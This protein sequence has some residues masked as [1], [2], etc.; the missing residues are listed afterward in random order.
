MKK[1]VITGIVALCVFAPVC[2]FS[3]TW[4]FGVAF[5]IISLVGVFEMAKCLGLKKNFAL[6]I[7]MYLASLGLPIL[8]YLIYMQGISKPN[9]VFL[10]YAMITAFILL[11]Y[12][13]AYIMFGKNKKNISDVLT[14]YALS[15]YTIGCFSSVVM[16]RFTGTELHKDIGAYMY[17][18]IFISAWVCD[19]FAYFVGRLLGKH[20]LIPEISPKK[21]VEGAIGGIVFTFIALV[22]YWCIVNFAFGYE[23]LSIIHICILGV[24]LPIVSQIGDL[25]ASSIKRQY[26]IKDFGNVFPG[27]G[28]VLD[29]FD[30][31][32]LVAPVLC[33]TNAI[34]FLF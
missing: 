16:V 9:S 10:R 32:M 23:G 1:R 2:I 15:V 14:F 33:F 30:S 4:F 12:S 22:G 3:G 25:I 20:K 29:R 17:L 34:I 7:P 5:G 13:L 6:T 31:A 11:I 27:H 18:L 24:V 21:T 19:T 28:G 8:R 26:N